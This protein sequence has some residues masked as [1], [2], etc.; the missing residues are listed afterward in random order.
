MRNLLVSLALLSAVVATTAQAATQVVVGGILTGATG[1]NVGGTSY[2][3]SFVDGTCSF[4]YG[5]CDGST[6]LPFNTA[7]AADL[8][9]IALLDQVFTGSFDTTPTLTNG[10]QSSTDYCEARTLFSFSGALYIASASQNGVA[11]A[12]DT[13]GPVGSLVANSDLSQ[14]LGGAHTVWAVWSLADDGTGNN[15][16]EPSSLALA[17]LALMGL[18]V[19]A[20]RRRRA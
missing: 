7:A 4:A 19:T 5:S 17:G 14:G 13:T 8:A 15:V 1:V 3:V 6:L 18:A 10:C 20:R 12:D 16:P 11:E 2:N 9:S